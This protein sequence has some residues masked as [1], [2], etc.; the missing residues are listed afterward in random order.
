[1]GVRMRGACLKMKKNQQICLTGRSALAKILAHYL[2]N[3]GYI[4]RASNLQFDSGSA[5]VRLGHGYA[6]PKEG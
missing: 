1:M 6:I 3:S 2:Y 5:S 4:Q